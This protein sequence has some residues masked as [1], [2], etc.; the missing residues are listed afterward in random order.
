MNTPIT[1][2]RAMQVLHTVLLG[3]LLIVAAVFAGILREQGRAV[4][5][6]D[7]TATII[8][9]ALT[10]LALIALI[11]ATLVLRPR[12]APRG[13]TPANE[14]WSTPVHRTAALLLWMVTEAAGW[15]GGMGYLL[16]GNPVPAAVGALAI[17]SLVL[18]S[19]GRLTGD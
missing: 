2:A 12:I 9:Y 3:G 19:P 5:P 11:V 7:G 15:I 13:S 6:A 1:T 10:G 4:L 16:T 17:A 14:Y 8:A 18:Q